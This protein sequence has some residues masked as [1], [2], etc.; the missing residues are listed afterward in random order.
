[1]NFASIVS[2][3]KSV[4][5]KP[6]AEALPAEPATEVTVVEPAVEVSTVKEQPTTEA[7]PKKRAVKKVAEVSKQAE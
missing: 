1:M 5:S 7:K 6:K 2:S 4:F 3:L